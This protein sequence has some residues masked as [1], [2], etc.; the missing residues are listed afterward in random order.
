MVKFRYQLQKYNGMKTKFQC[1]ACHDKHSFVKYID[2][3]TGQYLSDKVGRCDKEDKCGYHYKPK[4]YF[5][6]YNIP[7][8]PSDYSF[9]YTPAIPKPVTFIP[10]FEFKK[11]LRGYDQNRFINNLLYNVPYPFLEDDILKIID[12]YKLGTITTGK[13]KSAITFP[14]I[15]PLN[16]VRAIQIKLFDDNNHSL[17]TTFL[18]SII[19]YT[20]ISEKKPIPKWLNDYNENEKKIACLFGAHLLSQFPHNPIA[21]VEAP[22]TAIYG[23]QYFG[24]P[25]NPKNLLWLAVFNLS[26][27]T[28][29]KVQALK[30]RKVFLFPDLSKN[31]HAFNLWS[32]KAAD[33]NQIMPDT[34]FMVSDL[35]EANAPTILREKGADIADILINLHWKLFNHVVYEENAVQL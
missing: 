5:A 3:E 13:Y 33:F 2:T 35:L 31:G 32:E 6:D 11:T 28:L 1:P 8:S 27:L 9:G 14:Y 19:S 18:H 26:S 7:F 24:F 17:E 21:L 15:D 23:T 29:D 10:S 4:Q 16:N 30:G 12:L 25:D 20:L 22:K 34:Q